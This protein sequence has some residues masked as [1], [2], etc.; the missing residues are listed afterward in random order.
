MSQSTKSLE[1]VQNNLQNCEVR[2]ELLDTYTVDHLL[3]KLNSDNVSILS[4]L[5]PVDNVGLPFFGKY[6]KPS[7]IQNKDILCIPLCD[8]IHFQGYII[9]IK[10]K[11]IIPVDSLRWKTAEIS[12]AKKIVDLFFKDGGVSYESLFRSRKQFDS[13]SCGAWLI[14]GMCSY[15]TELPELIDRKDA[16]DICYSLLGRIPKVPQDPNRIPFADFNPEEQV[17]KFSNADFLINALQNGEKS[18]N[19]RGTPP[20]GICTTFFYTT[21]I[22]Q[23]SMTSMSFLPAAEFFFNNSIKNEA[24]VTKLFDNLEIS[25][26]HIL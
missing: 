24:I 10:D 16:F 25:I 11:K 12:T 15:V 18:D 7:Q 2:N 9:N 5:S 19:F 17:K 8:G 22:S 13:N 26:R 23:R 14:A 3:S 20:K 6:L 4:C 21:D 1:R